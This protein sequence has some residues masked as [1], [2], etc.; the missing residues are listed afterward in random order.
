MECSLPGSSIHGIF[1]SRVL[2]WIAIS[3]S[4]GSIRPRDWTQGSRIAGRLF[5][6]WAT[7]E[8]QPFCICGNNASDLLMCT[9][10]SDWSTEPFILQ[11]KFAFFDQHL[12]NVL[13]SPN[14]WQLDFSSFCVFR[15][16]I[17]VRSHS[18]YLSGLFSLS[19]MSSRFIQGHTWAGFPC[20]FMA[21]LYLYIHMYITDTCIY[22]SHIV[23]IQLSMDRHRLFACLGYCE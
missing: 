13:Y 8:A 4:R 15:F 2:E 5:T 6:L 19:I 1:Q 7:R 22:A 16:H 17:W 21:E 12:P 3:F 9:I 23:F 18:I 14:P 10:Q 20:F 11:L